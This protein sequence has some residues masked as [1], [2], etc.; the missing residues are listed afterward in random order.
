MLCNLRCSSSAFSGAALALLLSFAPSTTLALQWESIG[1]SG[2]RV[3]GLAQAASNPERMYA[4][5]Y[6]QGVWRSENRGA[7]WV[8]VD[9]GLVPD[10]V[11]EA[12]AV[13]PSDPDLVLLAPADGDALLRSTDGGMGWSSVFL[14]SGLV[15]IHHIAFDPIDNQNALLTTEGGAPQ[16]VYRSTDAGSSWTPSSTGLGSAIPNQIAY[17]PILNRIVLLA[18]N[19]GVFRS[20]NGGQSW[21]LSN[22]N[23]AGTTGSISICQSDPSQ[24]WSLGYSN[25]PLGV[26]AIFLRST[27]AGLTFQEIPSQCQPGGCWLHAVLVDPLDPDTILGAFFDVQCFGDCRTFVSAAR[28]TDA[29]TTWGNTFVPNGVYSENQ[30]VSSF[31]FDATLSD[32]AYLSIGNL[33]NNGFKVGLARTTN[34]GA[35]WHTWMNGLSG[36][37]VTDVQSDAAGRVFGLGAGE[38]I[39]RRDESGVWLDFAMSSGFSVTTFA[40]HESI[41]GILDV[42][43]GSPSS[44]T[45]DPG[46]LRST[47]SGASWTGIAV[48]ML[49]M[50]VAPRTIASDHLDGSKIYLWCETAGYVPHYLC[51]SI[52]G[53]EFEVIHDGF[54]ASDAFVDPTD[55]NRVFAIREEAPGDVQLS[56]DGGFIWTTRSAGLPSGQS[57]ALLEDLANPDH[58]AAVYRTVGV[59]V[60]EDGG[61]S[62]TSV[63]LPGYASQ[64]VIDADW[65]PVTDRFFLLTLEDGAYVNGAEFVSNGLFTSSLKSIC[66]DPLSQSAFVGTEYASVFRLDVGGAVD[67][68]VFDVSPSDLALQVRPN[69]S[70]GEF[71]FELNL[72][73]ATSGASF[74]I[75]DVRGRRIATPFAGELSRG[76]QVIDW[77]GK[78]STGER[79]VPGVYFVRLEAD[80]R[81]ATTRITLLGGE[82]R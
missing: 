34:A 33:A 11:Y 50:F 63:P 77:S 10:A 71:H 22:T 2:G 48:P 18:A 17:H 13:S 61:I 45:F 65:D 70:S 74:A 27:D 81:T 72:P 64:T 9:T 26:S 62:W 59:Y 36:L 80:R 21:T 60:T 66:Y 5:L 29:G 69:P 24:V 73:R 12:V 31:L 46:F 51:R 14:A 6:R 35:T 25:A 4:L 44:D 47:N 1:P 20:T 32:H 28:S 55:A 78:T 76:K 42:G 23:G 3:D 30:E 52:N 56:T 41:E 38:R 37:Y 43:G 75:F 79:A 82:S 49:D 57:T 67:A 19:N 15:R 16:G 58:F 68:S 39:W 7:S 53:Q 54:L 8:R 40:V